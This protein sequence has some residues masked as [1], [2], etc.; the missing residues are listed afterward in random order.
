MTHKLREREDNP[1]TSEEG[2]GGSE[3]NDSCGRRTTYTLREVE[4]HKTWSGC[5]QQPMKQDNVQ[6]EER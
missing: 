1:D 3:T 4:K 2:R 5:K 6:S